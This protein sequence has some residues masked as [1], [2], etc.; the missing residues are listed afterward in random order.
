MARS[1]IRRGDD[2]VQASDKMHSPK[3]F[4]KIGSGKKSKPVARY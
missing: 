3:H 1:R 2:K 4:V